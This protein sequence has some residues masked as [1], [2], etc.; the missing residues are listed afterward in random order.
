MHVA[1]QNI[2]DHEK[3]KNVFSFRFQRKFIMSLLPNDIVLLS[4]R[5]NYIIY[6][7]L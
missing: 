1:Y 3:R 5:A 2:E 4:L 6:A 7:S